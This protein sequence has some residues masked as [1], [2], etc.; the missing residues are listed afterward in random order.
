MNVLIHTQSLENYGYEPNYQWWKFK[1]GSTI[2][3]T[4][5][6]KIANAVAFVMKHE[7]VVN[8]AYMSIPVEWKQVSDDFEPVL[9]MEY[10][11]HPNYVDSVREYN[12]D[13]YERNNTNTNNGNECC[14]LGTSRVTHWK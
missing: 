4:G 8:G 13:K 10:W 5:C 1:G 3:V 6:D 14:R 2:L 12:K 11:D 9:D 7:S